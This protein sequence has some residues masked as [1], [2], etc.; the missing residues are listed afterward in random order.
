MDEL[1]APIGQLGAAMAALEVTDA[2][3]EKAL[4]EV[5][6]GTDS[7]DDEAAQR[8]A[9]RDAKSAARGRALEATRDAKMAVALDARAPADDAAGRRAVLRYYDRA[10]FGF[11]AALEGDAIPAASVES[12][13]AAMVQYADRALQVRLA[14]PAPAVARDACDG[15]ERRAAFLQMAVRSQ[16]FSLLGRAVA[17]RAEAAAAPHAM[18]DHAMDEIGRGRRAGLLGRSPG[19]KDTRARAQAAVCSRRTHEPVPVVKRADSQRHLALS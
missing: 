9:A 2:A 3:A 8:R 15:D 14:L 12:V 18:R 13:V 11:A 7:N 19:K 4:Q 16:T 1:L 17:R 6:N 10:V 5:L